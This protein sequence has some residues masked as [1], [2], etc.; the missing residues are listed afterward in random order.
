MENFDELFERKIHEYL[1]NNLKI[2]MDVDTTNTYTGG[3]ESTF[4]VRLLLAGEEIDYEQE[5]LRL[6]D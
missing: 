2:E 4:Q 6:E 5:I 1:K 3:T